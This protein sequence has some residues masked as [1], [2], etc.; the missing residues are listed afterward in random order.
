MG[1]PF[2][3]GGTFKEILPRDSIV[4]VFRKFSRS[5]VGNELERRGDPLGNPPKASR[6]TYGERLKSRVGARG[7]KW[8]P[9]ELDFHGLSIFISFGLLKN[10]EYLSFLPERESQTKKILKPSPLG[11][12]VWSIK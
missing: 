4:L 5:R 11:F 9:V 8:V 10:I 6:F 3:D 1:K 7:K 2:F 12:P